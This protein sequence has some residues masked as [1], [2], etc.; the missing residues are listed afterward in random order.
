MGKRPSKGAKKAAKPGVPPFTSPPRPRRAPKPIT[1]LGD[2]GSSADDSTPPEGGKE[3][4]EKTTE[5]LVP[6]SSSS[7]RTKNSDSN[8]RKEQL[9]MKTI[10]HKVM[11]E[12]RKYHREQKIMFR[13]AICDD[14]I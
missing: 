8:G 6:S 10:H 4:G 7:S 9:Q 3:K 5:G 13:E 12:T 2:S 11:L 1:R 14:R